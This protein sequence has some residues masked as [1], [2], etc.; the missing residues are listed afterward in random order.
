MQSLADMR[1]SYELKELDEKASQLLPHDQFR[2]WL[3]EA[4]ESKI[5]E[6]NA[7]TLGDENS[8]ADWI[9]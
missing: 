9:H 8:F 7:M 5:P 2:I 3:D 1:K 6:P 4:I